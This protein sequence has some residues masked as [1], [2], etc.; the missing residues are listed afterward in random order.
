MRTGLKRHWLSGFVNCLQS[1]HAKYGVD[2]GGGGGGNG[3]GKGKT[4]QTQK[5]CNLGSIHFSFVLTKSPIKRE[6]K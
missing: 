4:S 6:M 2:D 1:N 5:S 3:G